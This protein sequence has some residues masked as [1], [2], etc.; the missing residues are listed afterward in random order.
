MEPLLE[1]SSPRHQPLVAV[2]EPSCS[3]RVPTGR[4]GRAVIHS[5]AAEPPL[6][7]HQA[8]MM[9]KTPLLARYNRSITPPSHPHRVSLSVRFFSYLPMIVRCT[10]TTHR[11][12]HLKKN[13]PKPKYCSFCSADDYP[14]SRNFNFFF[15]NTYAMTKQTTVSHNFCAPRFIDLIYE[16][17]G[18]IPLASPVRGC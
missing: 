6:S 16:H 1:T 18:I 14:H 2:H 5:A 4:R 10:L 15:L 9:T 11:F 13:H 7:P 17:V 3:Q 8:M 12:Y